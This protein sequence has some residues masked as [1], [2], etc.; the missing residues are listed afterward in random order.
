MISK[1]S[2][3]HLL[4][5][6]SEDGAFKG[7]IHTA[8]TRLVKPGCEGLKVRVGQMCHGIFDF[9]HGALYS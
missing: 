1:S 6:A 3:S 9:K 8:R 2:G 5:L 4:E 7:T